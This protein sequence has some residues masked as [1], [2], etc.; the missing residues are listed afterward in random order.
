[1]FSLVFWALTSL[2]Q[3]A[4]DLVKTDLFVAGTGGYHTYRIPAMVVS[5]EGTVLV[6]CE[7]RKT[8]RSDHGDVDLVLRRSE[9]G[10]KTWGPMQLVYEEGGTEAITIGN[11]CPVVDSDTGTIWLPF[12]RDNDDVLVTSSN[13]DG[14]TWT[15][16]RKI[17]SD[18]KSENWT[19]YATGPG[20]GIQLTRGP[21]K[22]RLVIPCDHRVRGIRDR[23]PSMRSHVLYSDDHGRTWKRGEATT[24]A[25]N[26]CAVVELSDGSLMLNMR[27]YRG[28]GCRAIS[29]SSNGGLSW[30][31]PYDETVLIEPVCQGSLIQNE[32]TETGGEG[33]L[34]FSNPASSSGRHHL[35]VRTSFDEGKTWPISRLIEEGSSAYSCLCVLPKGRV[36]LVYEREDYERITFTSLLRDQI[37]GK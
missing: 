27:S 29:L 10:G 8:S 18:V 16:P 33:V 34:L 32:A 23:S 14:R 15:V 36:G 20:N 4:G 37:V 25:M 1:M 12:T 21:D 17:T 19:W 13:D 24:A 6:F 2:G 7:G 3:P 11:P 5:T 35:T 28:K 9:D 31:E 26:E 22:G 30:T